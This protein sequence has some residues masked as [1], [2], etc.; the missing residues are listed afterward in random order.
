MVSHIEQQI[1]ARIARVRAEQ[2]QRR[3]QRE[4][5][6]RRR[7]AGVAKRHAAKLFRLAQQRSDTAVP[8]DLFNG[9]LAASGA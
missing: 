4:E 3:Q 5:L 7:T 9:S 8:D 1:Q 2:E 6:A